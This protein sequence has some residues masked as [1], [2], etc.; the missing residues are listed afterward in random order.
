VNFSL[1][2]PKNASD[3]MLLICS[4]VIVAISLFT[5]FW[6]I[7]G[8]LEFLGDQGRDALLVRRMFVHFDPVFIGP[9]TSVGN[10]YLGPLYYYF[11]LPFLLLTY[12]SPVGPAYAVAGLSV[13]T[14]VLLLW[15]GRKL[16]GTPASLIGALFF[17]INAVAIQ[18]GRFSWN[19]NP[20]PLVGLAMYYFVYL[21]WR[22]NY[23]YWIVVAGMFAMLIQLHYITLLSAAAAGVI[24][25]I[26]L[27]ESLRKKAF[28][29][30]APVAETPRLLLMIPLGIGV[31]LLALSPLFLFDIK[32]QGLNRQAF[33]SLLF[34]EEAF[35]SNK[36]PWYQ[37]L[38]TSLRETQGRSLHLLAE[39]GFGENRQFNWFL[40]IAFFATSAVLLTQPK[41]NSDWSA[42]VV[43]F[44]FIFTGIL[45]TAFYRGSL[46]NHYISYLFGLIALGWGVIFATW[47]RWNKAALIPVGLLILMYAAFNIPRCP[48]TDAGWG[49]SDLQRVTDRVVT[50]LSKDE[51]FTIVLLT[52][53]GDLHGMN[54]RY[55]FSTR[56]YEPLGFEH[57]E[58]VNKLVIINEDQP[59][60][61]P[62]QT[63]IHE[64]QVFPTKTPSIRYTIEDG[65]EI[66]ILENS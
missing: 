45:G 1:P 51:P 42:H 38:A 6:N 13:L 61:D 8:S 43:L 19:P 33:S 47:I 15:W 16:V 37:N 5:R 64:I 58:Q 14:T 17:T 59:D 52:G 60:F 34:K 27:I 22:K 40:V 18:Y 10:M 23:R 41:R 2:R 21:A 24:F 31:V 3:W 54:Y 53:T 11:M 55:F 46:F 20:A 7:P 32:H 26:Q 12:P 25:I 56:G 9:V 49:I 66:L 48:L 57:I 44:S 50:D 30:K 39:T 63:N 36:I 28:F 35:K 65:P 4:L 29:V 62:T